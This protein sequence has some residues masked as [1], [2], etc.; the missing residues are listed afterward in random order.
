VINEF[1]SGEYD[2]VV[3]PT[4]GETEGEA[5]MRQFGFTLNGEPYQ[6][7]WTWWTVLFCI[8]LSLV[9][10]IMSVWC[11]NHVRFVT[12]GCRY[13]SLSRSIVA[14]DSLLSRNFRRFFRWRRGYC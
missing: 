12:G 6:L 13:R 10:V 7:V 1:E 4:T 9:C 5:I 3:N 2:N 11:L 8:G 14:I